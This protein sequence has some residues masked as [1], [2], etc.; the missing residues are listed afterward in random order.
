MKETK[1]FVLRILAG[2]VFGLLLGNA[3]GYA[4]Y[5]RTAFV[6][7]D[8]DCQTGQPG[9]C[10]SG[11]QSEIMLGLAWGE[12][13]PWWEPH[14]EFPNETDDDCDGLIDEGPFSCLPG[15]QRTCF[16]AETFTRGYERCDHDGFWDECFSPHNPEFRH[17]DSYWPES[18]RR[19]VEEESDRWFAEYLRL[20]ND[21]PCIPGGRRIC[22]DDDR[23]SGL[24]NCSP[25]GRWGFCLTSQ[26]NY[27]PR[28][29]YPLVDDSCTPERFAPCTTLPLGQPFCMSGIRFC[30]SDGF[31]ESCLPLQRTDDR[32]CSWWDF[33]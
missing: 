22:V 16:D 7:A 2:A 18:T 9:L 11:Y 25:H 3:I 29:Q 26:E 23:N 19:S 13:Q 20:D 21:Q 1:H 15:E 31:W 4:N 6:P 17:L 8:R 27:P 33:E 28:D 30:G 32:L 14:R 10:A 5:R 24:Q 12:C